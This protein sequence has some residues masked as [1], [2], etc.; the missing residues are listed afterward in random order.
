VSSC[1]RTLTT[2][3]CPQSRAARR[4]CT[5]DR[6]LLP[7][8]PTAANPPH[9]AAAG[10]L[11]IHRTVPAGFSRAICGQSQQEHIVTCHT[12]CAKNP[13]CTTG[14]MFCFCR[15]YETVRCPSVCL[16]QHGPT[17]ANPQLQVC[18]RGHGGPEISIAAAA[19]GECGQCHVVSVRS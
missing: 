18:C 1:L 5:I 4:C 9:A 19:T 3:Y 8:G 10:E 13:A 17:T 6:C 2:W 12:E 14:Y 7:A 15:V 16:S 11:E